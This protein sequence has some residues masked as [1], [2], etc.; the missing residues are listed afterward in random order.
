[1]RNGYA[2]RP[3]HTRGPSP[4]PAPGP[5]PGLGPRPGQGPQSGPGPGSGPGGSGPGPGPDRGYLFDENSG[6][7]SEMDPYGS[8]WAHMKIGRSHMA[9]DHF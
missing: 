1:M 8:V 7:V 5:G 4:G 2:A 3:A 9:Q 6:I